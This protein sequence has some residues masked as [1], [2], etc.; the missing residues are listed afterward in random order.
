MPKK[1]KITAVA[2]VII[3]FAI[4][5]A[6]TLAYFTTESTAHNVITTGKVEISVDFP[7]NTVSV[8]PA[9]TVACE[10]KISSAADAQPAWL[11]AKAEFVVYDASGKKMDVDPVEL[12]DLIS[13]AYGDQ[14]MEKDGWWYYEDVFSGDAAVS[15]LESVSFSGPNMTNQYQ[16]SKVEI[17][18]TAQAVQIIHNGDSAAEAAGWP[19]E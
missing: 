1:V 12:K 4:L 15:F 3:L 8:M 11:R 7:N 9:E 2:V 18:V 19:D 10:A 14:W 13:L 6:S 5:A 17:I 16:G